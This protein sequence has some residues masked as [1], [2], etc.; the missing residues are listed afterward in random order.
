M[1]VYPLGGGC[2]ILVWRGVSGLCSPYLVRLL[3]G[4]REQVEQDSGVPL[5]ALELNAGLLVYDLC[6]AAA[7]SD[8]EISCVLGSSFDSV[9]LMLGESYRPVLAGVVVEQV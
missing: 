2:L 7:L 5:V 6:K 1:V 8:G 9:R 4:F 3:A